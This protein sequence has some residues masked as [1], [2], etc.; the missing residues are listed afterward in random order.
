MN[1]IK[2]WAL[3]ILAQ[4]LIFGLL[5]TWKL[6]GNVYAGNLLQAILWLASIFGIALAFAPP[7]GTIE[8]HGSVRAFISKVNAVLL[9]VLL[10]GFGHFALVFFYVLGMIGHR[11]YRDQFDAQ[12]KPLPSQPKQARA[13]P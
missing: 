13:E 4:S 8:R 12:G 1:T 2:S 3:F 6:D 9:V 10:T 7:Q 5:I 11:V